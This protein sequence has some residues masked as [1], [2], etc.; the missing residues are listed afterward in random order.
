MINYEFY[1]NKLKSSPSGDLIDNIHKNWWGKYT[2][3][4][5]HHGYIQWLFPNS[6][7]SRFNSQSSPLTEKEQALFKK[8]EKICLRYLKSYEM[9]L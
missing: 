9:M 5:D 3:L 4:E 8:D 7:K 1:S 2:L 6:F